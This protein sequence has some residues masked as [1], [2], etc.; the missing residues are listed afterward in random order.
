M[1][2][3]ACLA[4]ALVACFA[5]PPA[6]NAATYTVTADRDSFIRDDR[7]NENNGTVTE[8]ELRATA[9]GGNPRAPVYGF[10][11][12]VIPANETIVSATMDLWV[13]R[14]DGATVSVHRMTDS[15]AEL[16]V[17]SGN[18][19]T[20]YA[21]PSLGTFTPS[22]ANAYVSVDMTSLARGW[23]N[24]SIANHGVMLRPPNGINASF[25]AREWTT[26]A[27]RPR[28]VITTAVV[29]PVTVLK[30]S[31]ATYDPINETSAPKAL[32][33]STVAYTLAVTNP[34]SFTLDDGSLVIVDATPANLKLSVTD[35]PGGTGPLLFQNGT[36]G[37][38]YTF[39]ALSSLT[40]DIEF[41]N[42]G[43]A[44]YDYVPVANAEGADPAVTHI[45]IRPKGAMAP[46]SSFDLRLRYLIN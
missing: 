43:G 33:G 7:P 46:G 36:S 25:T 23:R 42:N 12:P 22:T 35:V 6:A 29:P 15:W 32:P 5:V 13:T 16:T 45:R 20:D 9:V 8:L 41:S 4:V 24:G 40:D 31:Q 3:L 17:T 11:L 44:N 38:S 28:L 34:G 27:Q 26:V 37:L 18:S 19:G 14:A 30:S 2:R 39:T 21:A 10:T 1:M